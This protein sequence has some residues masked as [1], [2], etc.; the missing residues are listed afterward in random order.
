MPSSTEMKTPNGTILVTLPLTIWP[1]TWCE[2]ALPR[3]FL[4]A[5]EGQGD[6][7]TVEIDV[8]TSTV[9]LSPTL[10]TSD[11]WSMCFAGQLGNVNQAVNAAQVDECAEVDDGGPRR[12]RI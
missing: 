2:R 3:I 10:T 9:T 8:S 6:A 5:F 4:V 12:S 7:L 1:G 11:G